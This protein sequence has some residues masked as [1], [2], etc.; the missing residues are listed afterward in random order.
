MILYHGT[1]VNIE[2][3]DLEKCRPYKDFGTGFYLTEIKEQAQKMANRVVR[4]NGG[5]PVVNIY[6]VPDDFMKRTNLITKDFGRG[7]S[8]EWVNFV[9]NNRNRKFFDS[10]SR[11]CNLD[12]KYDIVAGPVADDDMAMLLRQYDNQLIDF[13][14]LMKGMTYKRITNQYSFHTEK[15]LCL[16]KKVGILNE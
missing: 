4:I 7:V 9:R 6:E 11:E 13:E 3:I 15:A 8:A 10:T 2:Q 1:N 14:T 5:K 12:N 16:L